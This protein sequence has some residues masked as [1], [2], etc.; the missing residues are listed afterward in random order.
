MGL[1]LDAGA[2]ATSTATSS[3]AGAGSGLSAQSKINSLILQKIQ[4]LVAANPQ[5][6]RSGIPNQLLSQLLMQPMK[7]RDFSHLSLFYILNFNFVLHLQM[8][9]TPNVIQQQQEDD[10]V[11]YEEMGVA[12]TYAEYWPAKCKPNN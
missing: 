5:F 3:T 9:T 2:A 6:L 1:G 7:V 12:E 10:D 8:P 11:D 4:A